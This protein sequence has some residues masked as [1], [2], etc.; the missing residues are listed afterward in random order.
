NNA[1][2][3]VPFYQLKQILTYKAPLRGKRVE[4]VSPENTSRMDCRTQSTDGCR[5][6]GCRFHAA[7][8]RVFDADWN[9]A[10]T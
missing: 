3:Q 10:I 2:S 5:R 6:Q 4:T 7:D 8:G 1:I 9:A